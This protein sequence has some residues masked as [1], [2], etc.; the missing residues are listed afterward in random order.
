MRPTPIFKALLLFAVIIG[1]G[2]TGFA[3]ALLHKEGFDEQI[4]FS[5][6]D[7]S[8]VHVTQEDFRD[9]YLLVYFGFTSCANTCPIQ[10]SKMT[11]VMQQLDQDQIEKRVTPV[12][13]TVDPERDT[14]E[15]L[16]EY[17]QHFDN[18][19][20][21]LTGTPASIEKTRASFKALFKKEETILDNNYNVSH[22]SVIYVVNPLSQIVGYI[23]FE[24]DAAAI[25]SRVRELIL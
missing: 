17:L 5:L 20:L 24:A 11:Q 3:F 8:G 19:F 10:M 18:R 1:L 4:Q 14:V 9:Q 6:L 22:T 13:I 7:H 23:P 16:A 2:I 15:R 21:G 12:L 25:T